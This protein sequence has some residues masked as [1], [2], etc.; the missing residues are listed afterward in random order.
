MK[1][2]PFCLTL[3]LILSS[4]PAFAETPVN[5]C[6]AAQS[7]NPPT[8]FYNARGMRAGA[9]GWLFS[10]RNF[11]PATELNHA[12]RTQ[13]ARLVS[14]LKAAHIT[15]L[16]S[17]IPNRLLLNEQNLT[18]E[19]KAQMQSSPEVIRQSYT[20]KLADIRAAGAIAPD[21]LAPLEAH[22]SPAPLFFKRDHHWTPDGAQAAATALADAFKNLPGMAQIPVHSFSTRVVETRNHK[23]SYAVFAEKACSMTVPPEPL[24]LR[25]T[26]RADAGNLLDDSHAAIVLAGTSYSSDKFNFAG[27][28]E[29]ALG[30][31]VANVS[32]DGGGIDNSIVTYFSSTD[33]AAHK[34]T[35]LLWEMP[36]RYSFNSDTLWRQIIPAING[37]CGSD[38]LASSRTQRI[39]NLARL[40]ARGGRDYLFIETGDL[41]LVKFDVEFSYANGQKDVFNM[42]RST[43]AENNGR[44]FIELNDQMTAPLQGIEL[45]SSPQGSLVMRLCKGT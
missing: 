5:L 1:P 11:L 43:R 10:L 45:K 15:L 40:N 19:I 28:L 42:V 26:V 27:A 17:L 8:E 14:H 16:V 7:D 34:P 9:E 38:A 20:S 36:D 12:A 23:G 30:R 39:D 21:L 22:R 31:E 18:P 37:D 25:Q 24:E 33:F 32:V 29:Q 44:F 2:A 13:M 41:A 4:L 35:F 6:T 3:A